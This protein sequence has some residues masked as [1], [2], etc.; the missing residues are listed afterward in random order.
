MSKCCACRAVAIRVPAADPHR[1]GR[2]AVA[3][4]QRSKPARVSAALIGTIADSLT[5][6]HL[7]ETRRRRVQDVRSRIWTGE[8]LQKV[9]FLP[10]LG[11]NSQAGTARSLD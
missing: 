6:N 2:P 10:Q 1:R 9:T 8:G 3:L 11:D 5:L 7:A 4:R